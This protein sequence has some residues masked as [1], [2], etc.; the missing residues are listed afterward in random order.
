MSLNNVMLV[1]G[2]SLALADMIL[3]LLLKFLGD[4]PWVRTWCGWGA[5]VVTSALL[6]LI[7]AYVL[8][9]SGVGFFRSFFIS[10]GFVLVLFGCFLPQMQWVVG[11]KAVDTTASH[12]VA[13]H[14]LYRDKQFQ[15]FNDGETNL[16]LWGTHLDNGPRTID[17]EPRFI[18]P[19]GGMYFIRSDALEREVLSKVS[20]SSGT[21][22]RFELFL[23]NDVNEEYV[24]SFILVI[25]VRNHVVSIDTQMVGLDKKAWSALIPVTQDPRPLTGLIFGIASKV[26][27]QNEATLDL[28]NTCELLLFVENPTNEPSIVKD[29]EITASTD[30][31]KSV[32]ISVPQSQLPRPV[33][34]D[35]EVPF[36]SIYEAAQTPIQPGAGSNIFVRFALRNVTY[37]NIAVETW[38]VTFRDTKGR[39]HTALPTRGVLNTPSAK[40]PETFR[41]EAFAVWKDL[42]TLALKHGRDPTDDEAAS[43]VLEFGT[44]DLTDHYHRLSDELYG[45]LGYTGPIVQLRKLIPYSLDNLKQMDDLLYKIAASLPNDLPAKGIYDHEA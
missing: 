7:V 22:V 4:E 40:K 25:H 17:P 45:L 24:A 15:I 42:H 20:D 12:E 33:S 3:G 37:D 14:L 32:D 27:A 31:G 44:S 10:A 35:P 28:E 34:G 38:R 41:Q 43:I 18:S 19:R 26:I 6:G 11:Y 8:Y 36:R 29:I 9:V 13:I 16:Q 21:S 5:F 2:I 1:L 23:K 30:D 39:P